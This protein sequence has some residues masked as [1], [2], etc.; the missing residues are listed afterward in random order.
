MQ[1]IPPRGALAQR[2]PGLVHAHDRLG[3]RSC[4]S[5]LS[6]TNP[7]TPSSISSTAALS[8]PATTMLGVPRAAASTT[9]SPYP[10]RTDGSSRHIARRISASTVS[11][12]VNPGAETTSR[13][14][15]WTIAAQHRLPLGPVAEQLSPQALDS[16]RARRDRRHR[17]RRPLLRDHAVRRTAPACRPARPSPA[18]RVPA[19]SPRSTVTSPRRPSSRNRCACRSE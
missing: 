17:E 4:G 11:A 10:S 1:R 2:R 8:W 15:C 19:Y 9:T 14:P 6:H 7:F 13:R 16:G 5:E 12:V 3:D 18:R